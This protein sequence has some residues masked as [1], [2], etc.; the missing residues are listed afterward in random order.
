M[1]LKPHT[2]FPIYFKFHSIIS[3]FHQKDAALVIIVLN[4]P[5]GILK[6]KASSCY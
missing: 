3:P 1:A 4:Y 5:F 2:K 6:G